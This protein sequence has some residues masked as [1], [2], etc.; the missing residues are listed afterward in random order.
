MEKQE[1]WKTCEQ[2]EVRAQE[3]DSHSYQ[4]TMKSYDTC[5]DL[6][7]C[8]TYFSSLDVCL[9][10]L[11]FIES[12]SI[13]ATEPARAR[14]RL[15]PSME[16]HKALAAEIFSFSTLSTTSTTCLF[17]SSKLFLLSTLLLLSVES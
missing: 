8:L 7:L 15:S 16:V 13:I 1:P 3:L 17:L 10:R 9:L 6:R 12:V 5:R 4:S 2:V 11:E 14:T